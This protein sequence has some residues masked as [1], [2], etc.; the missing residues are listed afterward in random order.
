MLKISGVIL[1]VAGSAGYGIMKISGWKHAIN[2]MEEW[3]LLFENVKTKLLYINV[4]DN[5]ETFVYIENNE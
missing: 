5:N 3:I 4:K 1:C 2:E